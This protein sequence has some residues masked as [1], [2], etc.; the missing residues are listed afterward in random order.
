MTMGAYPP[1][2]TQLTDWHMGGKVLVYIRQSSPDQVRHHVGSGMA[3]RAQVE[4][5]KAWGFQ[6]SQIIVIDEDTGR[7]GT[8]VRGRSGWETMT[9]GITADEVR[10]VAMSEVSR[11]GRHTV[12]LAKFLALCEW[13]GVLL[14]DNGRPRDLREIGDWT[15]MSIE[16]TLAEQENRRRSQRIRSAVLAKAK[17]GIWP[18][19]LPCGFDRGPSGEAIKTTEP[20]VQEILERIWREA[21]Q[22]KSSRRI[23]G[24][25]LREGLKL[26]AR[27]PRLTTRWVEPARNR[28]LRILK[29]PIYAGQ[30]VIWRR[31]TERT[32]EGP[33]ERRTPPEERQ[34]LEGKVELY[35]TPEEFRRVQALLASR[36]LRTG[37]TAGRGVALCARLIRCTRCDRPMYVAYDSARSP[38]R[39]RAHYYICRGPEGAHDVRAS[40]V[41]V[42]GRMLDREVEEIVLVALQSPSPAALRRAIQE[43]NARRQQSSQLLE[44]EVRKADAEVAEARASWEESRNR[45]KNPAVTALY[46]D[47]LE[48]KLQEQRE[49]TRR[50]ASAPAVPL[51]DPSAAFVG[52]VASVFTQFPSLWRSGRLGPDERK[53]IVRRVVKQIDVIERDESTRVHVIPHS[54]RVLERHLF[55][56]RARRHEMETLAAQGRNPQEIAAELNRRRIGNQFGRP[57]DATAVKRVLAWQQG[58]RE[59]RRPFGGKAALDALRTLWQDGL[60][61]AAIAERMNAQDLRTDGGKPWTPWAVLYWAKRLR[62]APRWQIAREA[63]RGPL[64][65]LAQAGWDDAAIAEDFNARGVASYLGRPWIPSRV[66]RLRSILGIRRVSPGQGMSQQTEPSQDPTAPASTAVEHGTVRTTQETGTA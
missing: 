4:L 12:E 24:D 22:G 43:E 50:L 10:V 48:A 35:V 8:S 63:L 56:P 36:N 17:A 9:A 39:T 30:F 11:L 47:E 1:R 40:C 34:C 49:A 42:S 13:K 41:W 58:P 55:G 2:P 66:K 61:Q 37:V 25:L 64:T 59:R 65:E 54:G 53:A 27:G 62:L 16:A 20:G 6:D 31:R 18:R 52:A 15:T 38:R 19:Q 3:Q 51:L 60:S 46:E 45:G 23:A 7:S 14:I 21:L 33:V 44:Q 5:L 29:N 32:P 57:F 26:P 28:V